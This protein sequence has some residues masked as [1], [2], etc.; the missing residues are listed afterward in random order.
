LTFRG[1]DFILLGSGVERHTDEEM[2]MR[3]HA[4]KILFAGTLAAACILSAPAAA[5]SAATANVTIE[6][7]KARSAT[8]GTCRILPNGTLTASWGRSDLPMLGFTIGP[9]AA[10]AS[11]M[12]AS[13]TPFAG[14]GRY[15]NEIIA[16]Y[17]GS[18]ALVDS[19]GGLGTVTF[20]ADGHS[21]TFKLNDGKASGRFDCGTPPKAYR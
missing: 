18:T 6:K 20:N 11:E 15:P 7:P 3:G 1:A 13:P 12:H 21:G 16:V 17:L 5:Q 8:N 10:M 14:P 4:R 19:Y 2:P 9:K